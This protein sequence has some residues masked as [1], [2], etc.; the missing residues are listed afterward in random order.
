ME[1]TSEVINKS[2]KNDKKNAHPPTEREMAN[3]CG[4]SQGRITRV[5][6]KTLKLKLKNR[7]CVWIYGSGWRQ[8]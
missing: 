3:N 2:S 1:A 6:A 8:A 4:V 5:I 7:K